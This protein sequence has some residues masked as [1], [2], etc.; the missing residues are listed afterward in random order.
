MEKNLAS[1]ADVL[2][3]LT[4]IVKQ[5]Q[6]T[7][8]ADALSRLISS[9]RQSTADEE[10]II[11][12][13]ETEPVLNNGLCE[14]IRQLPI[15]FKELVS[16][17]KND[18]TLKDWRMEAQF[19]RKHGARFRSFEIDEKVFAR[20]RSAGDWR[21]G[22]IVDKR[23]VI[24]T[25]EFGDKISRR[26]HANQLRAR[27]IANEDTEHPLEVLNETFGLPLA[28]DGPNADPPMELA[29]EEI[30]QE[31]ET[32]RYPVRVRRPAVRLAIDDPRKARYEHRPVIV[33]RR[34]E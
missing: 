3:Q 19:N 11:A 1:M 13:C 12:A 30:Q 24:Y 7:S 17:T 25:V 28:K 26:F 20:H 14:V 2:Q 6:S 34:P 22:R 33:N 4:N 32:R 23:G 9:K 29:V 31:P 27:R 5:Q 21:P 18:P 15:T 16:E 10:I 8:Q